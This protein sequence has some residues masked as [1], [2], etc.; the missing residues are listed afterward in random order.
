MLATLHGYD[1]SDNEMFCLDVEVSDGKDI[2]EFPPAFD[3]LEKP[4]YMI[5]EIDGLEY[6]CSSWRDYGL[7]TQLTGS[8]ANSN[9][10]ADWFEYNEWVVGCIEQFASCEP[11][12]VLF[13]DDIDP[14]V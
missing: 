4:Y 3:G 10:F 11:E 7:G 6:P 5:A 14:F 13:E 12:F 9:D 2:Y 8:G 1:D